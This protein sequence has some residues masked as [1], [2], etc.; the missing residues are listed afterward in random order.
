MKKALIALSCICASMLLAAA[1]QPADAKTE[2]K[3]VNLIRNGDFQEW[4]A[5]GQKGDRTPNLVDNQIPTYWGA[6]SEDGVKGT[7]SRDLSGTEKDKFCLK[8]VNTK[9]V[10]TDVNTFCNEFIKV[11]PKTTYVFRC[12]IKGQ[13][14]KPS[15]DK[16][17]APFV[18]VSFGPEDYWSNQQPIAKSLKTGTYDWETFEMIAESNE[19]AEICIV[20]L[21]L[22]FATGTVWYDDVELFEKAK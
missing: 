11:K 16:G 19:K 3:P 22:R 6:D 4:S 8:I 12:K 15:D 5:I 21:Q 14:I 1:D 18:W 13:D 2:A 10:C 7:V 20:R 17:G 9:T